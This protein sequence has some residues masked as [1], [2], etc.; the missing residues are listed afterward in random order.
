MSTRGQI[1][2]Y[3]R[4][5]WGLRNFLRTPLTLEQSRHILKR[6][7]E[8]RERNLLT[9]VR[10]T[11]YENKNSPYLKLL[12]LAGCEFGDFERI[13]NSDGVEEALAKLR[14]EGVYVSIEEF[15]GKREACRGSKTFLFKESDFDN[16][17]LAGQLETISGGSRSTGTRTIYDF[18]FLENKYTVHHL[19][20]Y[21]AYGLIDLPFAIWLPIIGIGPAIVLTSTKGGRPPERWFSPV[22]KRGFRPSFKNRMVANY[23]VEI[24]R[25]FGANIPRP[26]YVQ[27]HDA[28]I[29]SHWIAEAV[30]KHGGCSVRTYTSAAVR[31]CQAAK[32]R[33]LDLRGATFIVGGE[34]LTETKWNEIVSSGARAYSSYGMAESGVIGMGCMNPASTDD[35][36]FCKDSFGLIQ[37]PREVAHA[38]IWVDA[39]LLTTL[40]PCAPKILFNAETGDY[41]FL[42]SRNCGCKMG[43]IGMPDHISDIRGFDKLTGEGMTF[44]GSELVRLIDHVLPSKYGGSSND[45]QILEEEE[46]GQTHLSILVAP[47]VGKIDEDDVILTVLDE[48]GKKSDTKRMMTNIWS[49]A[50][51]LK[52]K[53]I[54]PFTTPRGKL[55]P[56]YIQKSK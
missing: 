36:H 12:K 20:G 49:Q 39:F 22:H 13:V 43:E 17:C 24:G 25:I 28:W 56:L 35:V 9:I 26:E 52:V 21:D 44:V 45:Y 6:R 34:P 14:R 51:T 46:N 18:D 41:G 5:A 32:E 8:E 3:W 48:L 15:K 47:E 11:I 33:G 40:L 27:L 42:K 29:V 16:P 23:I 54:Q 4:F 2:M 1:I 55:F 31:V 19:V 38:G 30:Q 10:S 50:G 37:H 53:R 7:L